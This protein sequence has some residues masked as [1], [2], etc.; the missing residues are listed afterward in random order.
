M[1][2]SFQYENG[3]YT[4]REAAVIATCFSAVSLPFCLVIAAMLGLDVVFPQFYLTLM[5]A[6]VLSVVVMARVWPLSK[7]P[8]EYYEAVGKQINEEEPEGMKKSEWALR[9]AV[10]KG[11][12][13]QTVLV[14]QFTEVLRCSWVSY[15]H[16]H[17]W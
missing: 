2:T 11:R 12:F 3:Y 15:S 4:G 9:L 14:L 5:V 6:G 16:L 8:D 13:A 1:L 7:F 17:H 10:Q